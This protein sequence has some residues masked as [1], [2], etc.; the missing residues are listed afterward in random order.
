[1]RIL[2]IIIIIF[3]YRVCFCQ[4]VIENNTKLRSNECIVKII[5]ENSQANLGSFYNGT[6]NNPVPGLGGNSNSLTYYIYGLDKNEFQLNI[7]LTDNVKHGDDYITIDEWEVMV[8]D[9]INSSSHKIFRN[10]K[11]SKSVINN[12]RNKEKNCDGL[13]KVTIYIHKISIGNNVQSG[14]IY[15][16]LFFSITSLN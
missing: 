7:E 13:M 10:D 9:E 3:I 11:F 14:T 2:T 15:L 8:D 5:V 4:E 16:N 12:K 6:K 1:M